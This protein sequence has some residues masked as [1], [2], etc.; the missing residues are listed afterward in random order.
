M[1]LPDLSCVVSLFLSFSSVSLPFFLFFLSLPFALLIRPI[2]SLFSSFLFVLLPL[3]SFISHLRFVP[4]L[5]H[6]TLLSILSVTSFFSPLIIRYLSF[7]FF[8]LPSFSLQGTSTQSILSTQGIPGSRLSSGCLTQPKKY[9]QGID[10]LF[11][12]FRAE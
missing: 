3:S 6:I 4:A 1:S 10:W 2:V 5:Y 11:R 7:P 8:F 9:D 12:A